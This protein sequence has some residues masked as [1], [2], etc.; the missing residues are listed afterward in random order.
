[1]PRPFK[2]H[3]SCDVTRHVTSYSSPAE[4]SST[5]RA[6]NSRSLGVYDY[7]DLLF[8]DVSGSDFNPRRPGLRPGKGL[9]DPIPSQ[10]MSTRSGTRLPRED[11]LRLSKVRLAEPR[12]K[13]NC[14]APVGIAAS[15][16]APPPSFSTVMGVSSLASRLWSAWGAIG[17]LR[18]VEAILRILQ[19]ISLFKD[20]SV[21]EV[22]AWSR[23]GDVGALY[24]HEDAEI[25]RLQIVRLA[26]STRF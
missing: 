3:D 1:M 26:L 6:P 21:L 17:V 22:Y 11:V 20:H 15:F 24:S 23:R 8:T 10:A 13:S 12:P 16:A 14:Q 18:G 9:C 2:Y 5:G 19:S 7:G 4:D 25:I